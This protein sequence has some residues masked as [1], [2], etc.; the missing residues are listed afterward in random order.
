MC[1]RGPWHSSACLALPLS[2]LF[3]SGTS[4]PAEPWR[5][6]ILIGWDGV[7][8]D[9]LA[10]N[11]ARNEVPNLVALAAD[12]AFVPID[13]TT[14]ATDTKAGW[15]QLLSGYAPTKTGIYN[16]YRY[17][18]MPRGYTVFERLEDRFGPAN[19][20][21]GAIA[22]HG[23]RLVGCDP[24]SRELFETWAQRA[25][26]H[27]LPVPDDPRAGVDVTG[28][29]RIIEVQGILYVAVPGQ[30]FMY[31]GRLMETFES[32]LVENRRVG[33]RALAALETYKSQRFFLFV[34]FGEPDH[35]GHAYGENSREY[36][37][38]IIDTDSWTGQIIDK[39]KALGLYDETLLYVTADHGFDEG[40][41]THKWAPYVFLATNDPHVLR[42]GDRADVAP[43]M[44]KHLGIDLSGI[45]PPLDGIPLDEAGVEYASL[46]WA[47]WDGGK[48]LYFRDAVHPNQ[49]S[50]N[51]TL[52]FFKVRYRHPSGAAPVRSR[53]VIERLRCGGWKVHKALE[54]TQ[55]P[56]DHV[57]G[58]IYS[59]ST[60]LPEGTL[61]YRF[62][63]EAPDVGIVGDPLQYL[64]G[65][66]VTGRPHLCW[67]GQP[68][69][70]TDGV[71]PGSGPVG[72]RF[73][74]RVFYTHGTG[75][76]PRVKQVRIRRNGR[77][78]AAAD[79][80]AS[81]ARD[82]HVGE[83]FRTT[84]RLAKRGTYE[85]RF[86]FMDQTGSA[87]GAPMKWHPGPIVTAAA[88]P[89]IMSLGAAA[90]NVGAQITFG[91][92]SEADVTVQVLNLAG[93]P[94]RTI[95]ADK[96]SASGTQM[97]PWNGRGDT[98]LRVPSGRYII[99]I[100]ARSHDGDQSTR[101]TA[102]TL[103]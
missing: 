102:V 57:A 60:Q 64:A 32:G 82:Y 96:P 97:V 54:M 43:T 71:E 18:P 31:A 72:Q 47:A 35:V 17:R 92:A 55:D 91:L 38:A 19:I 44:L 59:C 14:G 25:R 5:N 12:G 30:P 23:P 52:F 83:V 2:G 78:C 24:P 53:C 90:T 79:M 68:G 61:R 99:H 42:G 98:G 34:H 93:R 56:G 4:A 88:S 76:P 1:P 67:T 50:P 45:A 39:I 70:Q 66:R 100:T 11:I 29:G 87:I 13:I 22:G 73:G 51:D 15:P 37:E 62:D 69:F 48:G 89:V 46:S 9:H 33:E 74:F 86:K 41:M 28:G 3:L 16:L 6:C 103:R 75:D 101:L 7:G 36:D 63:F 40:K 49:G 77:L 81:P 80:I 21:T 10:E 8:R 84:V 65:P 58:A 85:Y 26:E 27:G 20:V 95:A 94:I